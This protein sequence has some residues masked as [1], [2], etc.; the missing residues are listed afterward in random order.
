MSVDLYAER[1]AVLPRRHET[2][3]W[4]IGNQN[5]L[6]LTQGNVLGQGM[7]GCAIGCVQ[8]GMLLNLGIGIQINL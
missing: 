6:Q 3:V 7:S 2:A 4:S 1:I 8:N 5:W